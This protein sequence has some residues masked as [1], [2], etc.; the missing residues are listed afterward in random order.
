MDLF[1]Q[2]AIG[3]LVVWIAVSTVIAGF[4]ARNQLSRNLNVA[5]ITLI[6]Y[7]V[8]VPGLYF[9]CPSSIRFPALFGFIGLYAAVAAVMVA[10]MSY[11][12]IGQVRRK[13]I[14]Q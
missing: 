1:Q 14:S 7:A 3:V 11:V 5:L 8:L 12:R 2:M 13:T 9:A 6:G 10:G 4:V